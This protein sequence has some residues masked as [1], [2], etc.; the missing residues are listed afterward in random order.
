MTLYVIKSLPV[1]SDIESRILF[2]GP[3]FQ[4]CETWLKAEGYDYD[5]T[6]FQHPQQRHEA[7]IYPVP[8]LVA[9]PLQKLV[10]RQVSVSIA[11]PPVT[12]LGPLQ[13]DAASHHY[14]LYC[15]SDDSSFALDMR[16]DVTQVIAVSAYETPPQILIGE[17]RRWFCGPGGLQ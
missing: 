8:D 14:T 13:Y 3:S 15:Q 4:K 11:V 7:A 9:R 5:G 17:Q 12:A 6:R 10:G 2:E 16:F 1:D